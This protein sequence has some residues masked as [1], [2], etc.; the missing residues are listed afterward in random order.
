MA[1]LQQNGSAIGSSKSPTDFL[2]SIKGKLV[3]VKLN[4]GVDYRG[5]ANAQQSSRALGHTSTIIRGIGVPGW[6]HEHCYGANRG[7][8]GGCRHNRS[9]VLVQH[10]SMSTAS[11]RTSM[12]THSSAATMVCCHCPWQQH[13]TP[14]LHS[15]VHQPSRPLTLKDSSTPRFFLLLSTTTPYYTHTTLRVHM[16]L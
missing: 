7:K 15:A 12:A 16:S 5:A 13:A 3:I 9:T 6:L 10:R 8:G 4:S 2:K 14:L 11:S 1:D